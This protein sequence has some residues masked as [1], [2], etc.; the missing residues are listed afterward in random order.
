MK[1]HLIIIWILALTLTTLSATAFNLSDGDVCI[2]GNCSRLDKT[3]FLLTGEQNEYFEESFNFRSVTDSG[4]IYNNQLL[5]FDGLKDLNYGAGITDVKLFCA[6]LNMPSVNGTHYPFSKRQTGGSLLGWSM[7]VINGA[8]SC[9]HDDGVGEKSVSAGS[10]VANNNTHVCCFINASEIPSNRQQ[11]WRNGVLISATEN[12]E[13]NWRESAGTNLLIGSYGA[14]YY[15]G[16]MDCITALG[17]NAQSNGLDVN[18]PTIYYRCVNH[19]GA[20]IIEAKSILTTN[21]TITGAYT[22]KYTEW[23]KNGSLLA[24]A[25]SINMSGIYLGGSVY[26]K[27]VVTDSENVSTSWTNSYGAI[28]DA[29]PTITADLDKELYQT[30]DNPTASITA[31]DNGFNVTVVI[32]WFNGF[33]E[34]ISLNGTYVS[35]PVITLAGGDNVSILA[36]AIDTSSSVNATDSA[37]T[38]PAGVYLTNTCPTELWSLFGFIMTWGFLFLLYFIGEILTDFNILGIIAG[39]GMLIMA[40]VTFGCHTMVGGI[41]GFSA[42]VMIV[43]ISLKVV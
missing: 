24:T 40:F 21:L 2:D 8:I 3:Q 43:R 34:T 1:L 36:T 33:N 5:N 27:I 13:N 32:N 41:M 37:S 14:N 26:A 23:Y 28:Y 20:P 16:T 29:I 6:M 22:S 15:N 25:D 11:A 12:T 38:S 19:S 4:I 17:N 9:V 7:S 35:N 31:S 39:I 10:I 30:G 42:L 18:V